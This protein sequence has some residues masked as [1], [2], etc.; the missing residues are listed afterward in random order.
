MQLIFSYLVDYYQFDMIALRPPKKKGA[1]GIL[2]K[3]FKNFFHDDEEKAATINLLGSY[4]SSVFERLFVMKLKSADFKDGNGP[5]SG[6][7][8]DYLDERRICDVFT[9]AQKVRKFF[10]SYCDKAS[11][12][13]KDQVFSLLTNFSNLDMLE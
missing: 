11:F 3:T 10:E 8:Q 1:L 12:S 9:K 4:M 7:S 5:T 6:E 13:Q 2:W